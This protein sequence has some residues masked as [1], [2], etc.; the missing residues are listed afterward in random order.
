MVRRRKDRGREKGEAEILFFATVL[1]VVG[2]I[3]GALWLL[4]W[5]RDSKD[6]KVE[7]RTSAQIKRS[8]PAPFIPKL[9]PGEYYAKCE[10]PLWAS[11]TTE[12]PCKI[13]PESY[14]EL[15]AMP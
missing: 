7:R 12:V 8:E 15:E 4:G 2:L 14:R 10:K 13:L 1:V 11:L 9:D 5:V 3:S 6:A